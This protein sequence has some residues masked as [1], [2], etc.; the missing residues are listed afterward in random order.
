MVIGVDLER[1]T[2]IMIG[3]DIGIVIE[4]GLVRMMKREK[5]MITYVNMIDE[6]IDLQ[7][8]TEFVIR[9]KSRT[10]LCENVKG[11]MAMSGKGIRDLDKDMLRPNNHH[12]FAE[13]DKDQMPKLLERSY[14]DRHGTRDCSSEAGNDDHVEVTKKLEISNQKFQELQKELQEKS[15]QKNSLLIGRCNWPS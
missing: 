7:I 5:D 3:T 4:N 1:K 11:S 9:T 14:S 2:M 6:G 12:K 10:M 8:E 13:R 15:Q